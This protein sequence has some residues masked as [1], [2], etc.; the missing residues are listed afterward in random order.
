MRK[1]ILLCIVLLSVSNL[2]FGQTNLRIIEE[3]KGYAY[4][5]YP[6]SLKQD[7]VF[8]IHTG[9]DVPF[10]DS[11]VKHVTFGHKAWRAAKVILAGELAVMAFFAAMPTDFS[12]WNKNFYKDAPTNWKRAFTMPPKIDDDPFLVNYI[13]HPLGGGIYYNGVRSQGATPLQSAFFSFAESTFF[14]YF[15]ESVAERPSIQD[16]IV[17]PLG[18]VIIGELEHQATMLMKRNGFNF[19]EKVAVFIINP[20]YVV[21]NGYKVKK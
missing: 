16:L 12:N 3:P 10:F 17:T 13:Q 9:S 11:A 7:P 5:Y 18:G 14:E 1:L 8:L 20:M 2:L 21:F 4:N 15:I 19:V 6:F